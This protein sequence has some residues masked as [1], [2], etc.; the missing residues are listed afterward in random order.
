MTPVLLHVRFPYHGPWGDEMGA[1][2]D[3]LARDIAGEP[4]LL[5]KLWLEAVDT[6][7]AGGAYLFADRASAQR[8]LDKHRAR[9]AQWGI[10][11][12]DATLQEVNLPLSRL[13]RASPEVLPQDR[14]DGHDSGLFTIWAEVAIEDFA[15]FLSVFSSAGLAARQRHGSLGAQAFRVEGDPHT[16][17]V[18]IDWADR[19]S[20]ER[21]VADPQVKATM[22]SGGATRPPVFT[23]LGRAG[24]YPA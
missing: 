18:L 19:A 24:R 15:Q 10:G 9:L 8:Y 20:F 6:G 14:A 1:A 23:L 5:W 7:T 16:A 22:R 3:G 13:S 17:R 11:E 21:F 4:G 12:I 2:H